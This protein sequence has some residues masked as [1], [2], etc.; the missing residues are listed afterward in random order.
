MMRI[1]IAAALTVVLS[2]PAAAHMAPDCRTFA[3]TVERLSKQ[4]EAAHDR[5]SLIAER[6]VYSRSDLG[7]LLSLFLEANLRLLQLDQRAIAMTRT[8]ISCTRRGY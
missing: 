7:D 2:A 6:I 8:L 1:L 3:G 5:I 4:K